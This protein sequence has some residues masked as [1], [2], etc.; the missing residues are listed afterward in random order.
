MELCVDSDSRG[1]LRLGDRK[2]DLAAVT[3]VYP[4]PHNWLWLPEL[5]KT[6]PGSPAWRRLLGVRDTP[7]RWLSIP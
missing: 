6:D 2:S 4:R 3:G 1:V 7:V 5:D